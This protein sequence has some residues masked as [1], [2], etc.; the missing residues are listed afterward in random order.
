MKAQVSVVSVILISGIVVSLVGASF[1]WGMPLVTKRTIVTEY[2]TAENFLEKINDVIVDIANTGA[3]SESLEI[4]TGSVRVIPH[5]AED[6]NRNSLMIDMMT[7]QPMIFNASKVYLGGAGF[8]DVMSEVGT[9]GKASPAVMTMSTTPV[10]TGYGVSLQLHYREL[11]TQTPPLKG[12]KILLVTESGETEAGS[13]QMT[14]SFV[15]TYT[16]GTARNGG[17]LVVTEIKVAV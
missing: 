13:G 12:Y 2:T 3:G 10:A 5:N 9:Y 7:D 8:E 6:V 16:S 4:P 17:P 15:R 11:D 1:M 14:V